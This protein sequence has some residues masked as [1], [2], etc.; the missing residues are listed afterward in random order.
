SIPAQRLLSVRA[1]ALSRAVAAAEIVLA[2][3]VAFL[4][5]LS[6][7]AQRGAWVDVERALPKQDV[8]HAR[9]LCLSVLRGA[10][11]PA[12]EALR[13]LAHAAALEIGEAH[14]EH[15]AR[16]PPRSR[17]SVETQSL[18]VIPAHSRAVIEAPPE[19]VLRLDE[20]LPRRL[21]QPVRDP[22][23]VAPHA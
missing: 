20:A 1:S 5:R 13:I 11:E 19:V 4:G 18:A 8:N 3:R 6:Q 17:A 16:V 2:V 22:A 15:R 12:P 9:S 10:Q 14:C 21:A 7:P 23:L